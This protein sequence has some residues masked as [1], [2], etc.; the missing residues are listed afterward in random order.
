MTLFSG[1]FD[2]LNGALAGKRRRIL[3]KA[4]NDQAVAL[5][6][7]LNKEVGRAAETWRSKGNIRRLWSG[8]ATLWSGRDEG[9]W[10]GWL[11]V[12]DAP[13]RAIAALQD[14]GREV[15]TQNFPD[16]LLLGM[17]GSSLGPEVLANSLGSAPH[18]PKLHVLDSTDPKEVKRF[19][20]HI[21]LARTLFIVSSKSGTTLETNVLMDYFFDKASKRLGR[22]GAADTS[23][24]LPIRARNSKRP[25]GKR[26]RPRL[27]RRA[28]HRRT[29]FG[30]F[31]LR[32]GAAGGDGP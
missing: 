26:L 8:D 20:S 23:S 12:V 15:R 16:V 29:L 14:F 18:F 2:K 4:L 17:G 6:Q 3:A 13:S 28:E 1:S 11:H 19:E 31:P 10:L 32:H 25:P 30:A 24:P 7:P 21:D 27:P 5:A 22:A 9:D